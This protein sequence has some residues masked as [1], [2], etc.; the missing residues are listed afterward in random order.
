MAV[1][2]FW[3]SAAGVLYAYAGYPLLVWWLA[4][5]KP[6]AASRPWPDSELPAVTLI[7]PVHNERTTI[8]QKLSNTRGLEYRPSGLT[9]IFV[10]DGSTDGT[11]D[12]IKPAQDDRIRLIVL[13]E[14]GGKAGALNAGLA[15]AGSPI[16][17]FSDASIMLEPDAI[18]AI[19]K[20]FQAPDIGCVS[21]ED[22]ITGGGG[23]GLYGRYEM[24]LRRQESRLHSLVGASG[25]F[26]AQRR[27]LC[28][29]FLPNVAPDFLSVLRTVEGGFRAVSEPSAVGIM[30][31]LDSPHDEFAR[32]VRTVLRGLT[33]LGQHIRLLNPFRYGVFAFEL[34][35]H[36][37][38]RWLVPVFLLA[39]LLASAVLAPKSLL[40]TLLLLLQVAFYLLAIAGV[41]GRL[42][43]PIAGPGR[44]A[45]Y[46]TAVNVATLLAWLKYARGARQEIWS[47]SKR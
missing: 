13:A 23:E 44:L 34:F 41:A 40:F 14:R 20:P 12:I 21:G 42:P 29:V 26:Y 2:V 3:L 37:V 6:A 33:T 18:R 22:R 5:R 8:T 35:S 19:V 43:S 1:W 7:V 31:A 47:P 36:K 46:F 39:M 15:N 10:S 24:F 45:T 28:G 16:V 32:K 4:R 27:D 9:A 11:A 17:V 38:M 25:S 30:R